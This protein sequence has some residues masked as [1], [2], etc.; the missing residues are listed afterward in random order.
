MANSMADYTKINEQVIKA[1]KDKFNFYWMIPFSHEEFE[2]IKNGVNLLTVTPNKKVP[3]E[4]YSDCK[5]KKVLGVAAGGGQQMAVFSALGAQCTLLD[6]SSEQ[7]ESD[8]LVSRREGYAINVVKG[9]MAERLPFDDESF[10]I[11]INPISNHYIRDLQP[12][13]DEIYR[14][15]KKG[16]I[17]IAGMENEVYWAVTPNTNRLEIK[18][19]VDPLADK[20]LYD[21]LIRKGHALQ[22]SHTTSEQIGC[23]L[24]AGFVLKDLYDD[25]EEGVFS[26]LN[27]PTSIATCSE[28]K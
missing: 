1:W 16:G 17:F 15:L 3:Y 22:F 10:D 28:K 21:D 5:G 12:F 8:L 11:V 9:D 25:T 27:I 7:I 24:K 4:W 2:S 23:Q 20:E 18:L 13:F 6:I 19:P 14:V 26:E